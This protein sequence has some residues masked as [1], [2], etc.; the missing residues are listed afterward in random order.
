MFVNVL[1]L[2]FL[3]LIFILY[4]YSLLVLLLIPCFFFCLVFYFGVLNAQGFGF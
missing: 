2:F 1:V 4:L 3:N